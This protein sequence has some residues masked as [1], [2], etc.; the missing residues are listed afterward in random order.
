MTH[1]PSPQHFQELA[2]VNPRPRFP[3]AGFERVGDHLLR[4]HAA[5]ESAFR[6][7]GPGLY[8]LFDEMEDKDPH[9]FSIL[10]T[11]KFG[12]LARPRRIEPASPSAADR[13]RAAWLDKLLADLPDAD[14]ALMHLLGALSKGMAVLEIVWDF[15]ADGRVV[16]ARLKPRNPG[17]FVFGPDGE[18]RLVDEDEI[19][20]LTT[21][22]NAS[23]SDAPHPNAAHLNGASRNGSSSPRALDPFGFPV[24]GRRLPDRKFIVLVKDPTDERP[25]G[26]GLLERLYW[27]WWFKKNNLKFWVLYNEKFGS[28][29]VVAKHQGVIT[30]D[31]RDRLTRILE[32]LQADTGIVIPEGMML[33]FL[34]SRRASAGD[35]Y[36]DLANWCNDEMTRAVLGQTLTTGEGRRGGSLAL[37]RVHEAVRFDYIRTDACFLMDAINTQL[38]RWIFDF[39]FGPDSP[40]PRWTIDLQPEIDREVEVGID[41]QL[42]QMG[43]PLPLRY[44]YEKYG[45]PEAAEGDRPL[46]YDDSNLF[47]YHLQ[48]GVI[49][50]N[51]VRSALGLPPVP[52]GDRPTSPANAPTS[53]RTQGLAGDDPLDIEREPE[54]EE[55]LRPRES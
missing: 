29:T 3:L 10:Q 40:A 38:V 49:T 2:A 6:F 42:L 8:G 52:W 13:D 43:V 47:Q 21:G 45:R 17:R 1:R 7:A 23:R 16:P 39:N 33:E 22:P 51:E 28:P 55:P 46:R 11:R 26:K 35:T 18:L 12:L 15:D 14:G 24:P 41:R 20:G 19:L 31:E 32:T 5:S 37:A 53:S 27:Y 34:E 30:P 54:P 25:Y 9:L 50:V 48:F 4:H 44:F 36:A